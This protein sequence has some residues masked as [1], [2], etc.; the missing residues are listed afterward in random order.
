MLEQPYMKAER[1]FGTNCLAKILINDKVGQMVKVKFLILLLLSML[2][3]TSPKIGPVPAIL[4]NWI[5][6]VRQRGIGT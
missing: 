4:S 1:I 5:R 6:N 2:F 3:F